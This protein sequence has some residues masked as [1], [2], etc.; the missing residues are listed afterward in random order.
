MYW[1][2]SKIA[3]NLSFPPVQRQAVAASP[4]VPPLLALVVGWAPVASSCCAVA[5]G[6]GCATFTVEGQLVRIVLAVAADPDPQPSM[7]QL[8]HPP[9]T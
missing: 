3:Q 8:S 5:V 1:V 6:A 7:S 9:P 4:E 2:S